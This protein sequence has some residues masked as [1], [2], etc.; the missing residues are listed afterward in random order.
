MSN[1]SKRSTIYFEPN[2]HQ[3][4]KVRA[5]SSHLSVSELVDE[6]VRLLMS[7]DQEDLA[8]FSERGSEKEISYEALLNDLKKHGKI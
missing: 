7:E 2:I 6:A 1:L 3:A 8:A 4:L 5:A